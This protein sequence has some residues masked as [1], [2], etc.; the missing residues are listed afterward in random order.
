MTLTNLKAEAYDTIANIEA[1]QRRLTELNN[2]IANFKEEKIGDDPPDIGGGS[3]P[4][5]P[6]KP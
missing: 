3:A 4:K 5:P 2:A 1:L 6:I